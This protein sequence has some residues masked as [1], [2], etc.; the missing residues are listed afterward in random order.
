M[1]EFRPNGENVEICEIWRK[2]IFWKIVL[3][4]AY[5][6]TKE[7]YCPPELRKHTLKFEATQIDWHTE[8]VT[9][10]FWFFENLR[11]WNFV[12]R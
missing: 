11:F 9:P 1:V 2:T 4:Y 5:G 10:Y 12:L 7:A 8:T 6:V 3:H